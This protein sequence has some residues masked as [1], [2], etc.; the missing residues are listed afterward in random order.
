MGVQGLTEKE[1][2]MVLKM[3]LKNPD[4]FKQA[5]SIKLVAQF[6]ERLSLPV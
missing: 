1:Y 6:C 4:V 3:V 2:R 5:G